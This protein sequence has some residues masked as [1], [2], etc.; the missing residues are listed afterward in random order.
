MKFTH[1]YQGQEAVLAQV[2]AQAFTDSEGADEGALIAGLAG[3]LLNMS[4]AQDIQVFSMCEDSAA[5]LGC[6][7]FTPLRYDGDARRVWMLSPV[8]VVPGA[9]GK[10][11]G[12]QLLRHGLD[13]LRATGADVAVTYGDPTY[14]SKVGFKPVGTDVLPAPH[15]LQYPQGWQAQHLQGADILPFGVDVSCAKPFDAPELW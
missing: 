15:P 3:D 2:F 1:L 6:I 12:Q 4:A 5:P 8:A 11:L 13:A 9:Q 14:Y 7:I 10:G